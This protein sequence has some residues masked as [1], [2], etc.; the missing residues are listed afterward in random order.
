MSD[1]TSGLLA[2]L[3][4]GG[5]IGFGTL[6]VRAFLQALRATADVS[7]EK[8]RTIDR[9]AAEIGRKDKEIDDLNLRLLAG[10]REQVA[11]DAEIARL[12]AKTAEG[13]T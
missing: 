5:L 11:K 3:G 2:L 8:N 6:V 13:T 4:G 12:K 9:Q 10:L 7:E 1:L